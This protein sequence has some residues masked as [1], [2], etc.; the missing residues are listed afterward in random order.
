MGNITRNDFD[1]NNKNFHHVGGFFFRDVTIKE[2]D[3]KIRGRWK[4][5]R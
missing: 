2:R 1:I 5:L 4:G 3:M